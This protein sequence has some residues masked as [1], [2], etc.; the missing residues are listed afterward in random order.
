MNSTNKPALGFI[1]LGVM[2][3][4]MC[5]N[6][7]EKSSALAES[8]SVFDLNKQSVTRLVEAGAESRECISA[9]AQNTNL[10]FLSLPGGDEVK[11][12]LNGADGVL[13]NARSGTLVVDLSTSPVGLTRELANNARKQGLDYIDAPVAR[14]RTAAIE[15]TLAIMAGASKTCFETVKPFLACMASDI[16]HCGDVGTGQ[17]VKI[18]NNMVLFQT[19]VG[20]SEALTM[21]RRSGLDGE[22][23]FNALGQ[24]SAASFAL[25][26]H[27]KKALL[28]TAFPQQAF[29]TKYAEKD[30]DYALQLAEETSTDTPGAENVKTLF[31]KTIAAGYG[32][33]YWPTLLKIID[34]A[35]QQPKD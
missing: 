27:G 29:S 31:E 17:L 11:S 13:Q 34:P 9:L 20:L 25:Q 10:I 19:V 33:D 2:G 5:R 15:G 1:G 30:L 21:A 22:T 8:V 7:L 6:L 35:L 18:M 23:L 16:M 12:V 3:E 24:G 4:P 32:D 28:P 14:T 26:N